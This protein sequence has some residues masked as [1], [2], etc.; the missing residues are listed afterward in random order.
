VNL[1]YGGQERGEGTRRFR[2]VSAV[3]GYDG[4]P[5]QPL[6]LHT[7]PSGLDPAVHSHEKPDGEQQ[8]EG[9]LHLRSLDKNAIERRPT[10]L[11]RE[12]VDHRQ[13]QR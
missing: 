13:R 8:A 4:M 2:G 7:V 6:G 1:F 3:Q 10:R 5:N 12:S 11:A 9:E